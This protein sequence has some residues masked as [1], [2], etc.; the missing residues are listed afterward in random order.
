MGYIRGHE[1]II[2]TTIDI[3]MSIH[4]VIGH[5]ILPEFTIAY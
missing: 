2:S 4:H 5:E 1:Y 3:G